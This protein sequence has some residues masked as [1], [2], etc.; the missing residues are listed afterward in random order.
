MVEPAF[1]RLR[2]SQPEEKFAGIVSKGAMVSVQVSGGRSLALKPGLNIVGGIQPRGPRDMSML[3][4]SIICLFCC[5]I[6]C[7]VEL[8]SADIVVDIS[9][10]VDD[11]SAIPS[12]KVMSIGAAEDDL[13]NSAVSEGGMN[14]DILSSGAI[15]I[16]TVSENAIDVDVVSED[17]MDI[18]LE[19]SD[20]KHKLGPQSRT[21]CGKHC[22]LPKPL[23]SRLFTQ[24]GNTP[25]RLYSRKTVSE[26]S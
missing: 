3:D 26:T 9:S 18:E 4:M 24:C 8:G 25:V 14:I 13:D 23:A 19:S 5:R 7:A 21:A 15:D 10:V 16:G 2:A 20:P 22:T 6:G 17:S 12:V 11:S 1:T